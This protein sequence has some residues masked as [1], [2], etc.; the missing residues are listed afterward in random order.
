MSNKSSKRRMKLKFKK[1]SLLGKLIIVFIL[2]IIVLN[3][4]R[5]AAY[6]KK[7]DNFQLSVIIQNDTN[8]EMQHDVYI[9]ENNVVYFSEDDMRNLFDKELYY[10]KDENNLR[11]YISISQ[12]KI[13]EI[14]EEKNHMYINGT[15]TKI[16]G[17]II[18]RDGI[19]YFPI[20]ELADV[21][22]LEVDY[23]SDT[24]KLNIEKLSE[25][26]ITAIVNRD[27]ELKYKMTAISRNVEKL[28]QGDTVTVLDSSDKKW[29]KVK[30]KDY[31][32]GY[33]KK[34]KLLDF[35]KTRNDLEL[36]N[37]E[38]SNFD[39]KN[40]VVI[41]INDESYE[42][43]DEKISTYENRTDL[44]KELTN[45]ISKEISTNTDLASKNI[46]LKMN[47]T[48]ISN[49]DNYYRFLKELKAYVNANGCFLIVVNNS[50]LNNDIVKDIAN[51]VV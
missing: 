22:N 37:A 9:D 1:D 14:T 11:R 41:E 20:S 16:K 33:V 28:S 12:S 38:F 45:K 31:Q 3:V 6:F 32:V 42:N 36:A 23:L 10:E 34:S 25:E 4:L 29:I 30:T 19:Y 13:L 27:T 15:F 26:K 51:I 47:I 35:T 7:E 2:L 21:Y 46:G 49:I 18:N 17:K 8:V 50:N 5:Y 48:L 44:A 24:N 43:F 39:L 40:D